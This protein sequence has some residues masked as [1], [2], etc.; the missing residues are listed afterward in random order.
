MPLAQPRVGTDALLAKLGVGHRHILASRGAG[1]AYVM[2]QPKVGCQ[3][4]HNLILGYDFYVMTFKMG[5]FLE[6][7]DPS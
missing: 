3:E 7:R 6:N 2:T 4:K 5:M 1:H